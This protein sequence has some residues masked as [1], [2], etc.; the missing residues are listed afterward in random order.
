MRMFFIA[1]PRP[2]ISTRMHSYME[3]AWVAVNDA[4]SGMTDQ[5]MSATNG[6]K[7]SAAQIVEH[8]SLAFGA[9]AA[10]MERIVAAENLEVRRP[11]M[12]DRIATFVVCRLEHIPSGRKAPEY[13]VPQGIG[14]QD[15]IQ[16]LRANLSAMDDAIN[17]AE[18]KWGNRLIGVHPVLG[19][20]KPDDWRKFHVV[21]ARHHANQIVAIKTASRRSATAAA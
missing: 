20:L 19:P 9:T 17:R 4:V 18:S 7:W 12:R 13:T 21:H 2:V 1:A 3:Q 16:K 15:A 6:E 11:T 10:G 5:Q 8:L 14:P